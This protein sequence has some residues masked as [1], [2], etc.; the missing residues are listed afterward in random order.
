MASL[1]RWVLDSMRASRVEVADA[2]KE[3]L[4]LLLVKYLAVIISSLLLGIFVMLIGVV[5]LILMG[6]ALGFAYST[7]LD[8]YALGFLCSAGTWV[9]V[10]FM[11]YLLRDK[12]IVT[13]IVVRIRKLIFKQ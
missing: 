5:A 8:S 6:V 7:L 10:G 1:L 9:L 2:H 13:P 4:L 3:H 11:L 12:I